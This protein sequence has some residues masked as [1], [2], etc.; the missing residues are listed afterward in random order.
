MTDRGR[1]LA[2]VALAA[3]AAVALGAWALLRSGPEGPADDSDAASAGGVPAAF[4]GASAAAPNRDSPFGVVEDGAGTFGTTGVERGPD[5]VDGTGP[6][7]RDVA[8]VDAPSGAPVDLAA[9][10]RGPIADAEFERL[11]T[12]LAEDPA[13]LQAFVD[14][15][16]SETDPERL[17][18]LLHLLGDIDDPAVL[19]LATELVY[20]GDPA[21]AEL[22]LDL[23]KR[24]RPG[25][26]DAQA[27][28]S[29]LLATETEA[30]L[31]VPTL[32]ALARPGATPAGERA[33][34]A[35]QVAL[36]TD[37]ADP[38]VRRSSLNILSRWS[39]D[40][41][42]TPRLVAG[43]ADE[44]PSV[45]RA[46]AFAFVGFPDQSDEVRRELFAVADDSGNDE[47]TRRGAL[48][49]LQRM[50]LGETERTRVASIERA[51]DT[52][53]AVR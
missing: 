15:I 33:A 25:D 12:K 43:L 14:E 35:G 34:L 18:R 1:R 20:S 49:A 9:L 22:G 23:L 51:L 36:L 29:G 27:V 16:R 11:A 8:R 37:H 32:T 40:A 45:R 17:R 19:A 4:E 5:A 3:V 44:D 52:R 31:L 10:G 30:R 42:H 38:A 13:L 39:D 26:P 50:E 48:L 2:G 53:P 6:A 28:V 7:H 24:V 41:T 21:V 47:G 46:A